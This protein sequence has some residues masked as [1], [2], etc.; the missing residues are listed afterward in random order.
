MRGGVEY[1]YALKGA[2][3]ADATEVQGTGAEVTFDN[4]TPGAEYDIYARTPAS[5]TEKHFHSFEVRETV[6]TMDAGYKAPQLTG[7]YVSSTQTENAFTYTV[8]VA[9]PID[10]ANYQ[11]SMDGETW[12]P[13]ATF[14][15]F[16]VGQT[17]TFYVKDM[18]SEDRMPGQVA[19]ITVTFAKLAGQATVTMPETTWAYDVGQIAHEPQVSTTTNTGAEYTLTYEQ[20]VEGEGSEP[21]T[22]AAYT[23]AEGEP[24]QPVDVGRY[25]VTVSYEA[26]AHYEA[27]TSEP[28]E[29]TITQR[30]FTYDQM[31]NAVVEWASELVYNGEAQTPTL[32]SV[33]IDGIAYPADDFRADHYS[34]GADAGT[35]H[36][37]IYCAG[38]NIKLSGSAYPSY[39][40]APLPVELEW[41][42]ETTFTYNGERQFPEATIANL[43]E[44]DSVS[45]RYKYQSDNEMNND[46]PVAADEYVATVERLSGTDSKNYTLEGVTEGLSCKFTIKKSDATPQVTAKTYSSTWDEQDEF[47][48]GDVIRVRGN[49]IPTDATSSASTLANGFADAGTGQVALFYDAD[50][51]GTADLQV[52]EPYPVYESFDTMYVLTYDT[53]SRLLPTG[54]KVELEVRNMGGDSMPGASTTVTVTIAKR[55]L[56]PTS[57]EVVGAGRAYDGTA[58]LPEGAAVSVGFTGALEGD[59]V[60]LVA[61]DAAYVSAGAGTKTVSAKSFSPTTD[62]E[63]VDWSQWY[64]AAAP[65]EALTAEDAEGISQAAPTLTDAADPQ[66][67]PSGAT[68]GNLEPPSFAGVGGE[69]LAGALTWYSDEGRTQE[70]S[71]G[72]ALG[73]GERTLWWRFV[74]ADPN[75]SAAE[76]SV[77]VSVAA[78]PAPSR[79]SF[80][81]EVV[82]VGGGSASAS[83][84]RPRE[85]DEVTVSAEPG[86]GR[87][88]ASVAAVDA[89]GAPVEVAGNGDGTWS[90][91]QPG[92]AVTVTVTFACG[93]GELCP[94]AGLPD[95]DRSQWYHGA[96]D[97]AL[98]S[99]AMSGYASGLFG[100][101]GPLAREQAAAVLYNLLGE[102]A[103]APAAP[104]ADVDASQWYARAV[105]WAV[106]RGVMLLLLI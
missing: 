42:E 1:N 56:T 57:I 40:I 20:F 71:E 14:D 19:T 6:K 39:E 50:K 93:G 5:N 77:S 41:S 13:A 81:V 106:D 63:G 43:V 82:A 10:G 47:T 62:A 89:S 64:E 92:S 72:D 87:V 21:D 18:G 45:P 35:Y 48:Y 76:G 25:R 67:L 85:G 80:P 34:A 51:D 30:E 61:T 55:A 15:G 95:V 24:A 99:G 52:S 26:T 74:P 88:V 97:W 38:D 69:P 54:E 84:S 9:D 79:P 12:Q 102:G 91:V 11:Y 83:P 101:G 27:V 29:F 22:W 36:S 33:T 17:Q 31:Q 68:A 65:A 7:S 2:T 4:L 90:F 103:G 32:K 8:Q 60:G 66:E 23:P 75:Y 46:W 53:A 58:G 3:P 94:S 78:P 16:T 105:A 49:I 104:H 28:V 37:A 73:S 44:G 96:V 59:A 98:E 70:L 86:E 100:P